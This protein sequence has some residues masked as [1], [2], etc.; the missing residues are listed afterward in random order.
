MD[1]KVVVSQDAKDDL[2]RY[3]SYLAMEKCSIQ[4]AT[5]LLD[6]YDKTI[7]ELALIA[8]SLKYCDNKRLRDRG[9]KRINFLKH[10]YFMLFRVED[11]TVYV[12]RIYHFLQDYENKLL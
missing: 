12:D 6:D 11:E 1:Y 10:R 5:N 7:D 4:A 8:G 3:V 2:E 9:Y